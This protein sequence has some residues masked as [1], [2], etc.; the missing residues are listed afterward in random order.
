MGGPMSD[1]LTKAQRTAIGLF[2][3][4]HALNG[5]QHAALLEL[6]GSLGVPSPEKASDGPATPTDPSP[7]CAGCGCFFDEDWKNRGGH[8]ET[9]RRRS[10]LDPSRCFECADDGP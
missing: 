8:E 7:Y 5:K 3:L 1:R 10:Y 2:V 6:V 4:E 9:G